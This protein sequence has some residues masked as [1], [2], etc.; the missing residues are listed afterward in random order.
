MADNAGPIGGIS[1]LSGDGTG[2]SG[3]LTEPGSLVDEEL[4]QFL[5]EQS[6]AQLAATR[7]SRAPS[8]PTQA[9]FFIGETV[10]TGLRKGARAIANKLG[11]FQSREQR[12]AKAVTEATDRARSVVKSTP[13]EL[14]AKDPFG[15]AIQQNQVLLAEFK[16]DGLDKQADTV[17]DQI[18]AMSTQ[19]QEFLKLEGEVGKQDVEIELLRQE[20]EARDV[21]RLAQ[22]ETTRLINTLQQLDVNTTQGASAADRINARLTKLSTIVGTTEFDPTARFDNVTIRKVDES[23]FANAGV[24]DGFREAAASFKPSF[25]QLPTKVKNFAVGFADILGLDLPDDVKSELQDFAVFRQNTFSNLNDYIKFITGAQ[26][27]VQEAERLK[28]AVPT[29]DDGPTTYL[30]KLNQILDK[31]T[32]VQA[33][34]LRALEHDDD[35]D[36]F[37]RLMTT[38]IRKFTVERT[39]EDLD[40]ETRKQRTIDEILQGL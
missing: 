6:E 22:D 1:G 16:A 14:R 32:A 9:G 12:E 13:P 15:A 30:A 38:P 27:S 2:R 25:L 36:E 4:L 24:I 11:I 5:R 31:L 40:A 39:D 35:P 29:N 37:R 18:L 10:G 23:I 34:S 28:K 19:Q 20:K 7:G 3:T 8:N 26:M 33:R 21:D 17:R